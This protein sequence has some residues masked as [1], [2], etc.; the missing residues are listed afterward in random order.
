M[1][2]RPPPGRECPRPAGSARAVARPRLPQIRTCP[3]KASGSSRRGFASRSAI[4]RCYGDKQR[5]PKSPAWCPPTA[6]Q[7]GTPFPRPGPGGSG[8][9]VSQVLRGA[10]T[11]HR[12]SRRASCRLA[13]PQVALAF[14]SQ[15]F[16]ARQRGPG[17]GKPVPHRHVP[18]KQGGT[19]QVPGEPCCA[20]AVFFDPGGTGP[21]GPC[22]GSARPPHIQLRRLPTRG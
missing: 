10:P 15:R 22:E 8:S 11:S 19:S 21:S 12:P 18:W 14:R 4:R 1:S 13:V 7:R 6:P 9:P 5:G 20:F 16:R 17:V 2:P 3:I